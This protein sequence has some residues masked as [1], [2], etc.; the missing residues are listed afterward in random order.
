MPKSVR[1]SILWM[2]I[3]ATESRPY[4]SHFPFL[5]KIC[6]A[7]DQVCESEFAHLK[8]K[9]R[10]LAIYK[11][12]H[13]LAVACSARGTSLTFYFPISILQARARPSF[14]TLGLAAPNCISKFHYHSVSL[15]IHHSHRLNLFFWIKNIFGRSTMSASMDAPMMP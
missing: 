2:T 14:Q 3:S 4:R 13:R 8:G 9:K 11:L 5:L 15:S 7:D 10:K 1:F 12:A 6:T